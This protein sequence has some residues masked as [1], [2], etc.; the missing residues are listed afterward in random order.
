MYRGWSSCKRG[1]IPGTGRRAAAAGNSETKS[2]VTV[3][4]NSISADEWYTK[5]FKNH[6][7]TATLQQFAQ[8][9]QGTNLSDPAQVQQ[10]Q[11]KVAPLAEKLSGDGQR[12]EQYLQTQCG[13]SAGS[14]SASTS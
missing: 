9:Y 1:A 3:K 8:A 13:I 11:A 5:V 10:L 12:L 4:I 2:G 6:D 7:F 14:T